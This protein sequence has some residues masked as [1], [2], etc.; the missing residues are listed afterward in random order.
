[1]QKRLHIGGL[2]NPLITHADLER[3]FSS[4][5]QVLDVQGVGKDANGALH[6]S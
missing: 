5:G 1:M 6:R 2:T 4:F 3:R